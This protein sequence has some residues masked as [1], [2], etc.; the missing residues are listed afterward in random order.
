MRRWSGEEQYRMEFTERT[1]DVRYLHSLNK[2][3]GYRPFIRLFHHLELFN[4]Y[5]SQFR[6]NI[7]NNI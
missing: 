7:Q 2:S 4:S 1:A 3:S 6:L 5:N